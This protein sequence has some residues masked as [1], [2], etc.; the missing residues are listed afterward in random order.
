MSSSN[1]SLDGAD[2]GPSMSDQG[3][4]IRADSGLV[5]SGDP[6]HN[7]GADPGLM[8]S[9]DQGHSSGAFPGPLL[10]GDQGSNGSM[11][12]GTLNVGS[13][14]GKSAEVV[15]MLKQRKVD[16]CCLQETRWKGEGARILKG[17]SAEYKFF[18]QGCKD[19]ISGVGILMSSHMIDQVVEVYRHSDRIMKIKIVI[20]KRLLSVFSIYAP[21]SGRSDEEKE[22]FWDELRQLVTDVPESEFLVIGGDLNGHV[23]EKTDG[24][25]GVHGGH[26]FGTRNKEGSMILEFADVTELAL[27]NTW[28]KKQEAKL[29]TYESGGSRSV[30]DYFMV[31]KNGRKLVKDVKA[32]PGEECVS[33]HRL[34]VCDIQLQEKRKKKS[35]FD[36]RL[37]V[38]KLK[39]DEIRQQFLQTIKESSDIDEN[40][41]AEHMWSRVRSTLLKATE[42]TCGRSKGPPRHSETWW[43]NKEVKMLIEEK[44]RCFKVWQK[45]QDGPEA[46]ARLEEYRVAKQQAKKAVA[47]AKERGR[48]EFADHLDTEDGKR[49]VFTI[50]R[51]ILRTKQDVIGVRCLKN[52]K[53]EVLVDPCSV[54]ERWKDY[55]EKLLNIENDWDKNLT[56]D[57]V[58]GPCEKIMESEV[59]NAINMLK[60]R[61]AGGPTEV[62]GEMF[63]ASGEQGAKWMTAICNQVIRDGE[64]PNDWKRSSLVPIYKG[65]GDPMEC[66]SYRA[67]KLLEHGMKIME[68]VLERRLRKKIVI[69]NMQF[70][71][72][73]GKGTVDA[74][75]VVRQMQE[76]HQA[77]SV[78]MH[79]AFVDLEKA[80]DRVPRDVV[81]WAL[82]KLGVDEWLVK[83]VMAMYVGAK[84]AVKTQDGP[85]GELDVKVGLHQGSVLSPLLFVSVMEAITQEIR[86]GLPWELL[87][88][89]DLVLIARDEQELKE[90]ISKWKACMEAKGLKMNIDKTKVMVSGRKEGAVEKSGKWPCGVCGKGVGTNS[91]RCTNCQCWI[92]R[93]CSGLKGRLSS[94]EATF[95]CKA[96]VQGQVSISSSR[97]LKVGAD[98]F[99][100]VGKFCYLGDMINADGGVE[101]SSVARIRCAWKKFRELSPILAAKGIPL[102]LK[103]KVYVACVRSAMIYGSETWAIKADQEARFERTE[104]RMVRWM[105][106]VSLR[107]KKSSAELRLQ[108]G[109]E[110]I[111]DVVR[112]SKLRWL[113]HVL[114]KD[115]NDWVRKCMDLNVEGKRPRGRPNKT[116]NEV[117][118]KD[119]KSVNLRREDASDRAKWRRMIHY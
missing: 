86:T 3:H 26:G 70:G 60:S 95:T 80:F 6:G 68:R 62:V 11:R 110:P 41:S 66:G 64:I 109:I 4:N 116:W 53:G 50:A 5:L 9:G 29:V 76:R 12:F 43:W 72:M 21:Q 93:K 7:I 78:E 67:I 2:P 107:D 112:R 99:E 27:C 44:K 117:I 79:Y 108:I 17:F 97:E 81:R 106:G 36:K 61:K 52:D 24:F 33:Q 38:W 59:A 40:L 30:I 16:V 88:A 46:L 1:F 111:N 75:F 85:S 55:M 101:S 90:K 91:I 103:G 47:K 94:Y 31:R 37:K 92:H 56:A 96:C 19:G 102:K 48:M 10:S 118:E 15:E 98:L 54:K 23:G 14:T 49:K 45:A 35:V 87:Y 13:M 115:C 100:R 69:D 89:D 22:E 25:E 58:E 34:V 8:L 84:T 51:Q 57:A 42:A 18:W 82:R 73:P 39:N 74:I 28:F 65:K 119:M 77:K 105:C 20:G 32:I 63:K 104:M 83:A 71:F 113:G 114:R